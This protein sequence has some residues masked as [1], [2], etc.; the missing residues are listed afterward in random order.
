MKKIIR[1]LS[2][3]LA[4]LV[5][6]T[7]QAQSV[8]WLQVD[9][10]ATS[11]GAELY[12]DG[13]Y[14]TDVPAKITLSV[15]K[16]NVIFKK[17]L[18]RDYNTSVNI[19]NGQTSTLSIEMQKNFNHV[20]ISAP[21][22][23]QILLDGNL[24]GMSNWSGNLLVGEY[25]LEASKK[26]YLTHTIKLN[27]Q[28]GESMAVKIP[29]LMPIKGQLTVGCNMDN[30]KVYIDKRF[31]GTTPFT[32]SLV[33]GDHCVS[34]TLPDGSTQEKMVTIVD[35]R[36]TTVN[37]EGQAMYPVSFK[38]NVSAGTVQIDGRLYDFS[39]IP[40]ALPAGKHNVRVT[41]EGYKRYNRTINVK[42]GSNTNYFKLK[43]YMFGQG[44]NA[45][46]LYANVGY[47][48]TRCPGLEW[49]VGSY[50]LGLNTEISGALGT[51]G[52]PNYWA[53]KFGWALPMGTRMRLTPQLGFGQSTAKDDY[54]DG[55]KC[56]VFTPGARAD[57]AI[58]KWL[59]IYANMSY[60][61]PIST[62]D[63]QFAAQILHLSA[64]NVSL[65]LSFNLN[66]SE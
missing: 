32:T 56:N 17:P 47:Q 31:V 23:A 43:K 53:F 60:I 36:T 22:D 42:E 63:P 57:L 40:Y 51:N 41:S 5:C 6:V 16:H 35:D 49:G 52:Y 33:I 29:E 61:M 39:D 8:G 4:L 58:A 11:E 48:V 44:L 25:T 15:G 2:V 54:Y 24:I 13:K 66:L 20:T 21:L 34:V 46:G 10:T 62:D 9:R 45:S 50:I 59:S 55:Y 26:G 27:V 64:L 65:G 30:C 37:F 12:V 38:S 7:V 1:L 18:Y 14:I 3:S 19:I 28:A